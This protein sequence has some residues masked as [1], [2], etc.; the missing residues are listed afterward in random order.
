VSRRAKISAFGILSLIAVIA[1]GIY[2]AKAKAQVCFDLD[3]SSKMNVSVYFHTK[4]CRMKVSV[5]EKA[6]QTEEVSKSRH[7]SVDVQADFCGQLE[8]Y[9]VTGE[10]TNQLDRLCPKLWNCTDMAPPL[11]CSDAGVPQGSTY[12]CA[13]Q[14]TRR[15]IQGL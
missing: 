8:G 1:V 13:A 5:E 7:S 11:A 6:M 10:A 9:A 15:A 12:A 2:V 14:T 4:A 3:Q